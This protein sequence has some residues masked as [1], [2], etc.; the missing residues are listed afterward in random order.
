MRYI[1]ITGATGNVGWATAQ[2]LATRPDG[3]RAVAGVR[4]PERETAKFRQLGV[5]VV[6]FDFAD[7]GSIEEALRQCEVLL[8][9]RPP[10]IS[11][12]TKFFEPLIQH[13]IACKVKHMVF[14]SVQGAE[15]S[16][17]IPHHKIEKLI[18]ESGISYTFLRP[19]YFMQNFTTSLRADIV[20]RDRIFLPAGQ[21]KFNLIDVD[22]IGRVAAVVLAQPAQHINK[23]YDLTNGEQLTFSDMASQ[24]S[25]TLGRTIV[26]VSPNLVQFFWQ[27]RREKMPLPL[28]FVMM[29]LHF[30]PRLQ[31]PLPLSHHVAHLTGQP[32]RSFTDFITRNKPLLENETASGQHQMAQ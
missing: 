17:V 5:D 32:P 31:K 2:A 26:F 1:L 19:A 6:A 9:V 30:L 12:V 4:N 3:L 7:I 10:A 25:A 14:L 29:M 8:L 24:L 23:A 11:N 28:I 15:A 20:K 21:A 18:I 16:S 13:A 27:K 22:D